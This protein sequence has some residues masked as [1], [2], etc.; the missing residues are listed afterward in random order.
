VLASENVGNEYLIKDKALI[1]K[2]ISILYAENEDSNLRQNTLGTLQK[3]SLRR[4]PQTAMINLNAISWIVNLLQ[5]EGDLS[6]YTT[7]YATS[8]LMN[9][10]LR[11][12]GMQKCLDI[13]VC[14]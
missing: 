14:K 8:L 10:A 11:T 5:K 1:P 6:D 3:L 4:E 2:L 9:L 7:E 12:K 13:K